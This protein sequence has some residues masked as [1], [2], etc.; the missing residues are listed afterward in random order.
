LYKGAAVIT[1]GMMM[2]VLL[3]AMRSTQLVAYHAPESADIGF[4]QNVGIKIF[5]DFL[6]PFEMTSVLF[7]AAMIGAV[8][9]AK[10]E[11]HS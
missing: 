3:A 11:V 4:V 2:L 6:L 1:G 8:V 9:L 7:I 5:T 10:K